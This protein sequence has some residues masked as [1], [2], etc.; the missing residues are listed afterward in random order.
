M[1]L[2]TKAARCWWKGLFASAP[3]AM[4]YQQF[5]YKSSESDD[6][7]A[8]PDRTSHAVLWRHVGAHNWIRFAPSAESVGELDCGRWIN[9]DAFTSNASNAGARCKTTAAT[10]SIISLAKTPTAT[11]FRP[12]PALLNASTFGSYL[13][14]R[15]VVHNRCNFCA[16]IPHHRNNDNGQEVDDKKICNDRLDELSLVI[17]GC[18]D[19][20]GQ[21]PARVRL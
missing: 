7:F 5:C 11:P 15:P 19:T 10:L 20:L 21:N 2:T 14:V 6:K 13:Q 12:K 9:Q 17:V 1:S 18:V 3:L 4:A 16:F 8:F